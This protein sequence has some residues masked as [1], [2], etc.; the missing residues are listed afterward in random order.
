VYRRVAYNQ[1]VQLMGHR[2]G[3][4]PCA[5]AAEAAGDEARLNSLDELDDGQP[6]W[7]LLTKH[8]NE[9]IER[10]L[11]LDIEE[12][13]GGVE[14]RMESHG[15]DTAIEARKLDA[16]LRDYEAVLASTPERRLHEFLAQALLC[17]EET[18]PE[19][20]PLMG[21]LPGALQAR[22]LVELRKQLHRW[23]ARRSRARHQE[24]WEWTWP[25][26]TGRATATANQPGASTTAE[27]DAA[28]RF[29]MWFETEDDLVVPAVRFLI[30]DL[31]N[32]LVLREAATKKKAATACFIQAL[33]RTWLAEHARVAAAEAAAAAAVTIELQK[34]EA[35]QAELR[36]AEAKVL[37]EPARRK[38]LALCGVILL[39]LSLLWLG[40]ASS[41]RLPA[42][43]SSSSMSGRALEMHDG[44]GSVLVES[45][46]ELACTNANDPTAIPLSSG[47]LKAT[48][49][50][51]PETAPKLESSSMPS[52][53]AQNVITDVANDMQSTPAATELASAE[54]E[55]VS[56][57][58]RSGEYETMP[59][60]DGASATLDMTGQQ[61]SSEPG[62]SPN[63]H[64]ASA[65]LEMTSQQQSS[66]FGTSSNVHGASA[67]LEVAS[68]QQVS[69]KSETTPNVDG[70]HELLDGLDL[71][72][73]LS[74][75]AAWFDAQGLSSVAQ[76]RE[77]ENADAEADF[78]STLQLKPLQGKLFH[79]RLMRAAAV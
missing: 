23:A 78:I 57:K 53:D 26:L 68:Q 63:V 5:A 13:L 11:G 62:T 2:I 9:D 18:L 77:L 44:A 72:N 29:L 38:Q 43:S 45:K 33:M 39:L 16:A 21:A 60:V 61:Q 31:I 24:P 49:E 59:N 52:G 20:L 55:T 51:L 46:P 8:A 22:H 17:K 1:F 14:A 32:E 69:S 41:S 40:R 65:A 79:K 34:V 25:F 71:L 3:G 42:I 70:L 27:R 54:L 35:Q 28:G 75:A 36:K 76:L 56:H 73:R 10:R 64:G 48:A 30:S 58:Q 4:G 74:S 47:W 15:H 7:R 19:E 12:R 67:A 66:D 6:F 50:A 37:V